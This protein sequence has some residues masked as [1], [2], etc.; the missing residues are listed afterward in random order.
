M[1]ATYLRV[2]LN[3]YIRFNFMKA[4]SGR[5]PVHDAIEDIYQ[6]ERKMG[7]SRNT[8]SVGWST[9]A[10][11]SEGIRANSGRLLAITF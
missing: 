4:A 8:S 3:S 2:S 7:V 11:S 1:L 9:G 10:S 5:V 6:A